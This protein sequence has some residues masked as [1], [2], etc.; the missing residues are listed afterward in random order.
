MKNQRGI[1]RTRN[2]HMHNNK[3][4]WLMWYLNQSHHNESDK[5]RSQ[6]RKRNQVSMWGLYVVYAW[7]WEKESDVS[8]AITFG[9]CSF[10][11][12]RNYLASSVLVWSAASNSTPL[13]W[14]Q[15]ACPVLTQLF[16]L[17]SKLSFRSVSTAQLL[18]PHDP[19]LICLPSVLSYLLAA[20]VV[21]SGSKWVWV[22]TSMDAALSLMHG[23]KAILLP[24]SGGICWGLQSCWTD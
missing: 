3:S 9:L 20:P 13:S 2:A 10:W 14:S 23:C 7:W 19:A 15:T 18:L 11:H 4:Q 5:D 8:V 6:D 1:G 21:M 24:S 22:V 16:S 17:N 12:T